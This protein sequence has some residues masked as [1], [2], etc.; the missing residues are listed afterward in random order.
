VVSA[1]SGNT[2]KIYIGTAGLN[3]TTLANTLVVLAIPTVNLIP[4]FSCSL[5]AAANA[6]SLSDLFIDA[7]VGGEGVL[8]SA[9]VA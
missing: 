8:I 1:L 2:G 5:T 9:V 6:L 7:D 4:T 3:K